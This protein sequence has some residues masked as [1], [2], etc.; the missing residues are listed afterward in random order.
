MGDKSETLPHGIPV[1]IAFLQ[2]DDLRQKYESAKEI[3]GTKPA[4]QK[5]KARA[6]GPEIPQAPGQAPA[7]PEKSPTPLPSNAAAEEAPRA[8]R[9]E[10]VTDIEGAVERPQPVEN[11]APEKPPR[12]EGGPTVS[13]RM[14]GGRD[15]HQDENDADDEAEQGADEVPEEVPVWARAPR[16]ER[17]VS[18]VG[19]G[20]ADYLRGRITQQSSAA[21]ARID[22]SRPP[23]HQTQEPARET[24]RKLL[25]RLW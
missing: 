22:W 19:R 9:L 20:Y 7:A 8:T 17:E 18:S 13:V 11:P 4:P 12:R 10:L 1:R 15:S 25:G 23:Q 5:R 6:P 21:P 24:S 3:K 14:V 2:M 16:G